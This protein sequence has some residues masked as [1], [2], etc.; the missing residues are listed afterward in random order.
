ME[1]HFI[2]A[3]V[4]TLHPF[5]LIMLSGGIEVY[6]RREGRIVF[7]FVGFKLTFQNLLISC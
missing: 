7:Y 4:F 3:P 5:P 6:T 1:S 2:I